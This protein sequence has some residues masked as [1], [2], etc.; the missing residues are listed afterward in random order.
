MRE[1]NGIFIFSNELLNPIFFRFPA[2]YFKE[3]TNVS[4]L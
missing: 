3:K 4:Q 2:F 1:I